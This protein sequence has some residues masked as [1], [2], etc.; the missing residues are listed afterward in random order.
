MSVRPIPVAPVLASLPVAEAARLVALERLYAGA[1][2]ALNNAL[3]AIGGEAGFLL[4]HA[5]PN[6]AVEEACQA[7]LAQVERCGRLTHRV[8]GQ[9]AACQEGAPRELPSR[10]TGEELDLVRVADAVRELLGETLGARIQLRIEAPVEPLPVRG[11]RDAFELLIV[12]LVHHAA[13]SAPGAVQLHLAIAANA[14]E[15]CLDLP[16]EARE[17]VANAAESLLDPRLAGSPLERARL[18]WIAS[19]TAALGG[20]C[21]AQR[22]GPCGWTARL[23]FA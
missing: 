21:H 16:V 8:L 23:R 20:R 4:E 7:V 1:L 17:Q 6:P 19:A 18:E 22:T 11:A 2:H 15:P 5:K 14:G 13:E 3:T 9:R 10:E 12:S